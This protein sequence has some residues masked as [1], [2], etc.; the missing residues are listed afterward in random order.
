MELR[1]IKYEIL[2]VK[3][4]IDIMLDNSVEYTA[5]ERRDT[6]IKLVN[7]LYELEKRREEISKQ[8]NC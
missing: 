6:L 7:K 3:V 2:G 1:R 4:R 5:E 8:R